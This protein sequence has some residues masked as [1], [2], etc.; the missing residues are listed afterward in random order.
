MPDCNAFR[1]AKEQIDWIQS[2]KQQANAKRANKKKTASQVQTTHI[3]TAPPYTH[4]KHTHHKHTH[5]GYTHQTHAQATHHIH[6]H[7]QCLISSH[8]FSFSS[9]V[10]FPRNSPSPLL[11]SL[12]FFS[13]LLFLLLISFFSLFHPLCCHGSI[14]KQINKK[15]RC[16]KVVNLD[17]F[18]VFEVSE[19]LLSSLCLFSH[20]HL[21]C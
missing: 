13:A 2:D 7:T 15:T 4:H 9:F 11:N 21:P 5:T 19:H 10:S 17:P 8:C 20:W 6:T 12:L 3:H 1:N 16:N 14:E 18:A